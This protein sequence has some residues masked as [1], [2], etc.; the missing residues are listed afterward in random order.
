MVLAQR[1]MPIVTRPCGSDVLSVNR[2]EAWPFLTTRPCGS[3][4]LSV[5]RSEAWPFLTT[6]PC[7]SDVMSVNRSKVWPFNRNLGLHILCTNGADIL[8]FQQDLLVQAVVFQVLPTY[9]LY[10]IFL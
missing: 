2:S 4:V 5:N 3:D 9:M 10:G 1:W 6:R 8:N 7:G